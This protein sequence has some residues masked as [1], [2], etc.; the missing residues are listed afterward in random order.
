[1]SGYLNIGGWMDGLSPPGMTLDQLAPMNPRIARALTP[2]AG[3]RMVEASP[4]VEAAMLR[5]AGVGQRQPQVLGGPT[6]TPERNREVTGNFLNLLFDPTMDPAL[7]LA[8]RHPLAAAGMLA[9]GA[10]ITEANANLFRIEQM[11]RLL[12][13]DPENLRYQSASPELRASI[14][15]QEGERA[16]EGLYRA[17]EVVDNSLEARPLRFPDEYSPQDVNTAFRAINSYTLPE[18]GWIRYPSPNSELPALADSPDPWRFLAPPPD[19]TGLAADPARPATARILQTYGQPDGWR[20]NDS[21]QYIGD[22][23]ASPYSHPYPTHG[24]P[25]A[26]TDMYLRAAAPELDDTRMLLYPQ[27]DNPTISGYA[28]WR[29]NPR[30]IGMAVPNYGSPNMQDFTATASH[31]FQHMLQALEGGRLRPTVGSE[32][33]K[34]LPDDAWIEYWEEAGRLKDS[35]MRG[36]E[37]NIMHNLLYMANRREWEARLAGENVRRGFN[38]NPMNPTRGLGWDMVDTDNGGF[39]TSPTIPDML[40]RAGPWPD[41]RIW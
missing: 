23:L 32:S 20:A 25:P 35:G 27:S 1:M 40:T 31:E 11:R 33:V 8:T 39:F 30:V 7:M 10:L 21:Q 2:P 16:Q 6:G 28:D 17:E 29:A 36:T 34:S 13:V 22:A 38:Q 15:R 41:F 12:R 26:F 19:Y 14:L 3:P 37:T 24:K 5:P 18:T 4:E 9:A